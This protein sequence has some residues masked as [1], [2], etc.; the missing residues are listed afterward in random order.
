M[1]TVRAKFLYRTYMR[2]GRIGLLSPAACCHG[3]MVTSAS[4]RSVLFTV[5]YCICVHSPLDSS[6]LTF[7]SFSCQSCLLTPTYFGTLGHQSHHVRT[8]SHG[9]TGSIVRESDPVTLS[10]DLSLVATA[11]KS[12]RFYPSRLITFGPNRPTPLP[13]CL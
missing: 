9:G 1:Y 13:S 12:L 6:S 5:R 2:T 10:C 7:D 11:S 3:D 8:A 4:G